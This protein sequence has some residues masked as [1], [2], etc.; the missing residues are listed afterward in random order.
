MSLSLTTIDIIQNYTNENNG[1]LK[2][3]VNDTLNLQKEEM[4]TIRSILIDMAIR[5][6][7]LD[8]LKFLY[9]SYP[10]E[11]DFPPIFSNLDY[12]VSFSNRKTVKYILGLVMEA[13]NYGGPNIH[14]EDLRKH[15]NVRNP[16]F[17]EIHNLL[18]DLKQFVEEDYTAR[19][20]AIYP[21][22]RGRLC[23]V[24][25]CDDVSFMDPKCPHGEHFRKFWSWFENEEDI[26]NMLIQLRK[27]LLNF[28]NLKDNSQ[29]EHSVNDAYKLINLNFNSLS[30]LPKYNSLLQTAFE[31]ARRHVKSS[32]NVPECLKF[33]DLYQNVHPDTKEN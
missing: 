4:E 13:D 21:L 18:D 1:R 25:D 9:E 7:N 10:I 17:S 26:K 31:S 29:K 16:H 28:D 20:D 33:I 2:Q 14:L 19:K 8:A 11:E 3:M 6:G 24:D 15:E 22:W 27:T 30:A 5:L 32:Q 23:D 12:A